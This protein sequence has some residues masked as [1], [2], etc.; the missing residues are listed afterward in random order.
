MRLV[1]HAIF[2]LVLI[3]AVSAAIYEEQIFSEKL[4]YSGA[5]TASNGENFTIR[6]IG[7][8]INVGLSSGSLIVKNDSCEDS[9]LYN[10]CLIIKEFS[11]YNYTGLERI[12]NKRDVTIKIRVAKLNLTREIEKTEFWIGDETEVRMRIQNIGERAT[13]VYFLDNFSDSFEAAIPLNCDLK[14]NAIIL[15]SELASKEVATCT[16]RIKAAKAGKFS[17]SATSSYNNGVS[18]KTETDV[19]TL[20]V[21]DFPLKMSSNISNQSLKLGSRVTA[22]FEI[23]ATENMTVKSL[24]MLLPE[25][26]RLLGW[27]EISKIGDGALEYEGSLGAGIGHGFTAT[28]AAEKTGIL[29]INEITKLVLTDSKTSQN[30]ER[31][32]KVNV[33]VNGLYT[34]LAKSNFSKGK[35]TLD[36][37]V[38]NPSDQDFYSVGLAIDTNLPL[39]NR[40]ASFS[41][42]SP[43]GHQEFSEK[44]DAYAGDYTV[45]TTL[46]YSSVY[47]EK[48][49][50]TTNENVTVSGETSRE[51]SEA[52]KP[53]A[54]P[55]TPQ[56]QQEE[57]SGSQQ[58][59]PEEEPAIRIK[60]NAF[61]TKA[62]IFATAIV[63]IF[64]GIL[65]AISARKRKHE[66]DEF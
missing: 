62:A 59:Q 57:P 13:T 35:N 9:D 50:V 12:V 41:K 33:S 5:Y 36:I 31:E 10:V 46:T 47:G 58:Q 8:A 21:K 48:F 44:F 6:L 3:Q 65:I 28:F 54:E 20:S 40:E 11:H 4:A 49:S 17:S 25:G 23:N 34:R 60:K 66:E 63:V 53:A 14:G 19:K 37:F 29:P 52:Q 51:D 55:E 30:F 38:V 32:I 39:A 61:S 42:V 18:N 26:L 45:T 43:F 27:N 24:K 16:Y 22:N 64:A 1:I 15:K 7:D 56:G 2:L